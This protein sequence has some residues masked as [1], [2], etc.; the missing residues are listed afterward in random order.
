MVYTLCKYPD[1]TEVVFSDIRKNE[2]GEECIRITFERPMDYG[3]DTIV[4]EL[5]SYEIVLEDGHFTEKEK[6]EFKEI[7]ERGAAFFFK[8]ARQGGFKL[9]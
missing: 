6:I 3:F 8:Y 7:V 9:A 2:N 4:F 1:G 5:P